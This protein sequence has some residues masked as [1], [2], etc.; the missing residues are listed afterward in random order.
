[1][2]RLDADIT[3]NPWTELPLTLASSL[4]PHL[5]VLG[6]ALLRAIQGEVPVYRCAP[7]S[8]TGRTLRTVVRRAME[9]FIELIEDPAGPREHQAAFFQRLGRLE[10]LHGRGTDDVQAAFRVAARVACRGYTAVTRSAYFPEEVAFAV[11]DAVLAHIGDLCG[12]VVRG[13][14]AARSQ[15][16]LDV[17]RARRLLAE[18]L[19]HRRALVSTEALKD[20]AERAEWPLPARVSCFVVPNDKGHRHRLDDDIL[21]V[22]RRSGLHLVVP[23]PESHARLHRLRT[24]FRNVPAVAGPVVPLAQ[25]RLSLDVAHLAVRF[26][27]GPARDWTGLADAGDHLPELY[28]LHGSDLTD[29]LAERTLGPLRDLPPPRAA[30]LADTLDALLMSW[31]R[32]APEVAEMLYIHPQ[33]ARYRLRQLDT[34]FGDRLN[35]PAFRFEAMLALRSRALGAT[36]AGERPPPPPPDVE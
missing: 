15:S 18:R 13:H 35:D 6:G 7:D 20:L 12:H 1:M 5:P 3:E 31:R 23:D 14:A 16:V 27:H 8:P 25:A 9:D 17:P 2:Q 21:V 10:F 34:L 30:R 33:T 29:L 4:R 24:L 22:R 19:L 32:S 11:N 36:R 28:L 26:L